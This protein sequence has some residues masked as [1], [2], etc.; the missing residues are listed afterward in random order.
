MPVK[1][2][3]A[4]NSLLFLWTTGPFLL[5]AGDVGSAWGFEYVT[6]AFVWDKQISFI[7]N[8]TNSQCEYCLLF[9]RGGMI[10]PADYGVKQF[11]SEKRIAHSAKPLEIRRR[12]ERMYPDQRKL[13]LFARQ[14]A[15]GWETWGN[16]ANGER[17]RAQ[18]TE[19]Q[20]ELL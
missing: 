7:G 9:R 5:S 17:I 19:R 14:P 18:V 15:D 2:C 8:Y 10:M 6:A 13:E 3:A 11:L 12:I 4:G 1:Q 16:Q 20:E